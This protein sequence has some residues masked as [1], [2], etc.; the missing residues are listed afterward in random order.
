MNSAH[1]NTNK[2]TL[3]KHLII[4]NYKMEFNEKAAVEEWKGTFIC[5]GKIPVS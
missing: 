2:Q 1:T 5:I 4:L 3:G